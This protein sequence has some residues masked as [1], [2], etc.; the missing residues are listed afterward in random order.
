M[1]AVAGTDLAKGDEFGYFRFGGSDII[2]AFRDGVDP[3]IDTS[4]SARKVGS[5]VATATLL[6]SSRSET[7]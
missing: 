4:E 2:I 6:G 5:V 7:R 1:T 3:R